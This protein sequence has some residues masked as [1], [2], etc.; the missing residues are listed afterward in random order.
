MTPEKAGELVDAAIP[1]VAGLYLTLI[2]YRKSSPLADYVRD[3][4][5]RYF[6]NMNR[7][8]GPALLVFGAIL[9]IVAL[10]R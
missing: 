3:Q 1:L 9:T 7:W 4:R 6:R 5:R 8:L 2:G 10:L